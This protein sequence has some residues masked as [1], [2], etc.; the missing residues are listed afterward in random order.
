MRG[1]KLLAALLALAAATL[2]F[3]IL[4]GVAIANPPGFGKTFEEIEKL[5]ARKILPL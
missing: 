3:F 2:E 4:V 5:A 1:N